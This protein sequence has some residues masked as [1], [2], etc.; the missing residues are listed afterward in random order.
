M[1]RHVLPVL[2]CCLA[3]AALETPDAMAQR[4]GPGPVFTAGV[5]GGRDFED[6]AW[7]LGGQVGIRLQ[8]RVEIRPS[9]DWYLGDQTPFRWQ[10]NADATVTF[11]P[12]RSIYLGGGAAFVK[13]L[14][15]DKVKTGYNGFVGLD[16]APASAR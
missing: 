14:A 13:V 16:F 15:L 6:H 2:V 8:D 5:R 11:G 3:F 4:G 7:S 10:L 12:G 9:G 1:R